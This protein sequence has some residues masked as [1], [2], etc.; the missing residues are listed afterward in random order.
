MVYCGQLFLAEKV[1][2]LFQIGKI[3][4]HRVRRN[5]PFISEVGEEIENVLP[6][7]DTLA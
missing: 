5:V 4:P 1:E 2:E 7:E 6:H 3:A